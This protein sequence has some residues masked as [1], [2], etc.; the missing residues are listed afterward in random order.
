M[1]FDMLS[2]LV[3]V[4]VFRGY[5]TKEFSHEM[6]RTYTKNRTAAV[7]LMA[8]FLCV[9]CGSEPNLAPQGQ[10]ENTI[11]ETININTATS[12]ELARIPYIGES[13]AELII[14]FRETHGAFKRPEQ[15]MQIRGVSDEKFRGTRHLIRTE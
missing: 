5:S 13:T 9:G 6:A 10:T 7:G 8:V 2:F 11:S 14:E 12:E 1:A 3:L 15:L 4:R